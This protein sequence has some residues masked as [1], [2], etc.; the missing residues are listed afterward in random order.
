M[1]YRLGIDTGG[2]FTDLVLVGDEQ[3]GSSSSRPRRHRDHP[4]DAI[5]N[6]LELVAASLGTSRSPSFSTTAT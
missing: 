6:G 5:R 3:A 2:T 1:G 4:P